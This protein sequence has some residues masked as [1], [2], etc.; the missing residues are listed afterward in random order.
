M[1]CSGNDTAKRILAEHG[2][3]CETYKTAQEFITDCEQIQLKAVAEG[4]DGDEDYWFE[5]EI[6]ETEKDFLHSL[7]ED[8]RIMLITITLS[9]KIQMKQ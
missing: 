2:N 7:L 1:I 5:D 3:Q 8:Y 4:K 6:E 9:I